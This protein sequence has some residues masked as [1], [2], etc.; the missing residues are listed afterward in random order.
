MNHLLDFHLMIDEEVVIFWCNDCMNSVLYGK[1]KKNL[2]TI[3]V[4]VAVVADSYLL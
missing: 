4:V 1:K 2:Q 3:V